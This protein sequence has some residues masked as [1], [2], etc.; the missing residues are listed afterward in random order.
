MKQ[1]LPRTLHRRRVLAIALIQPLA[2]GPFAAFWLAMDGS[3]AVDARRPAVHRLL[4]L[5]APGAL[6]LLAPEVRGA[7]PPAYHRAHATPDHPDG[8]RL[9][10]PAG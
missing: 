6:A 9:S 3:A 4:N 7:W 8:G 1:R 10:R 5:A 2:V